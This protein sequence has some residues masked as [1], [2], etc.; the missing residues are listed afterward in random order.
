MN[1]LSFS[2]TRSGRA[3]S[4]SLMIFTVFSLTYYL[5]GVSVMGIQMPII[6]LCYI[7]LLS[8]CDRQAQKRVM[9]ISIILIVFDFLFVYLQDVDRLESVENAIGFNYFIFVS[10]FPVLYAASGNFWKIDRGK[11]LTFLYL[12]VGLTASTTI[13][14]SFVYESPCRELATPDN[15]DLDRLYKAHN[16]GGYGFIYFIVLFAPFII[17]DIF[18][19]FSVLKLALL[20]LC[21]FCVLR[22]EYTTALLLFLVGITI[23]LLLYLKSKII[24]LLLFAVIVVAVVSM[25]DILN[26]AGTSLSDT[27]I[28]MSKRF[29]MMMDYNVYGEAD[30]D[31]GMRFFLYMQSL[32]T[33]IHRPLFGNLLS[34]TKGILGGH[35]EILDFLGNSGLFGLACLISLIS[36]LRRKTPISRIN[37]KDPFIKA[38]LILALILAFINTFLCPELYYA[39]LI[40]PLLVDSSGS[41]NWYTNKKRTQQT[42][43]YAI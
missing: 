5:R 41:T 4:L 7:L 37:T 30:D 40:V 27:S 23:V 19:E 21:G 6:L 3:F 12:V 24:R 38:S 29:D 18:K 28:I 20:F 33:F 26:W 31:L 25:Q 32:N 11:F 13:L 22:S 16:I 42:K 14:G 10:F 43:E 35:S 36:F 8:S 34:S 39:I 2:N 15:V 1:L 9:S 17:R